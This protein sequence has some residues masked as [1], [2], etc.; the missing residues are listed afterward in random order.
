M[1]MDVFGNRFPQVEPVP[2]FPNLALEKANPPAI[3]G[4][5]RSLL[6]TS[7]ANSCGNTSGCRLIG[8][9]NINYLRLPA[10]RASNL[11]ANRA[12]FGAANDLSAWP[13][14]IGYRLALL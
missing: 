11:S 6:M 9:R 1:V 3:L 13:V 14:G 5:N 12:S 4:V 2:L 8:V 10:K 7:A